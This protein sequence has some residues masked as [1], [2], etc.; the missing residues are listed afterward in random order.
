MSEDELANASDATKLA[1]TMIG[2]KRAQ[3][4]IKVLTFKIDEILKGVND[5]K[6]NQAAHLS[7]HEAEAMTTKDHGSRLMAGAALIGSFVAAVGSVI[8]NFRHG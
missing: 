1:V 6:L 3:E 4:D 2:L 7:A 5:I 8:S